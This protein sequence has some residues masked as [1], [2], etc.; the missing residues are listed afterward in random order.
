MVTQHARQRMQ[1]RGTG[2]TDVDLLL[3]YGRCQYDRGCEIYSLDHGSASRLARET[4]LPGSAID[5]LRRRYVV[6]AGDDVVT[7]A[8]RRGPPEERRH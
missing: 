5:R 7:V 2:L 3:A 4:G 8:I 1:Q 6:A